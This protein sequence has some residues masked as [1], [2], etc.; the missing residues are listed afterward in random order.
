MKGKRY[1]AISAVGIGSV[2]MLL[3][4]CSSSGSSGSSSAA[5]SSGS[6]TTSGSAAAS[7]SPVKLMVLGPLS[8][9]VLSEPQLTAGAQAAAKVLN[10]TGGINGH[11]ID[12]ITCNDQNDPNVAANCAR[13]AVSD[14]VSAVVGSGT[15]YGNNVDPILQ[16]ASIPSVGGIAIATEDSTSPISFPITSTPI[17]FIAHVGA[18]PA[19]KQCSQPAAISIP[20]P[21]ADQ[22]VTLVTNWFKQNVPSAKP[23]KSL[24]LPLTTTVFSASVG[25]LLNAGADCFYAMSTPT[26]ALGG[27]KAVRAAGSNALYS[28][29]SSELPVP[30]LKQL[31]SV[32]N[33]TW[34]VSPMALA[35]TSPDANKFAAAMAAVDPSASVDTLSEATYAGVLIVANVM[36]NATNFS[37]AS[38]LAA[39]NKST[40][41]NIGL[42]APLD[43]SKPAPIPSLPRDYVTGY[44]TYQLQNGKLVQIGTG[45]TDVGAETAAALG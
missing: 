39:L 5:T 41:I 12:I 2:A 15:L 22:G 38:V 43:F 20:N 29:D 14:G 33:G 44:Y 40:D 9:A 30:S 35:G 16:Q 25:T 27:L 17:A 28:S 11:P 42:L 32:A 26:V 4:A 23:V 24:V 10:A 36:K 6:A 34:L 13:T 3:A 1:R 19:S 21:A 37:G 8:S 7:G 31:G 45:T 18:V